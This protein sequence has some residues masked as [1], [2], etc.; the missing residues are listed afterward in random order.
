MKK[1]VISTS[2]APA[3]VGPYSQAIKIGQF[4]FMSGQI[5]LD[6]NTGEIVGATPEEQVVRSLDNIK[7]VLESLNASMKDIVKT[8]VFMVDLNKFAQVN[9]V[10]QKYF[11]DAPPAR[12]CVEVSALPKGALIEVEAIAVLPE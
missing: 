1:E 5:P 2:N 9:E 3:A 12:S 4:L 6:P 10:Y 8:T 11:M 7:A